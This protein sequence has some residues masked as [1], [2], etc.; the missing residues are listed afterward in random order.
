MSRF[1][2]Y[3]SVAWNK[4]YVQNMQIWKLQFATNDYLPTNCWRQIIENVVMA[5]DPNII[6]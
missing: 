4:K 1:F 3:K 5:V 2:C 6:P